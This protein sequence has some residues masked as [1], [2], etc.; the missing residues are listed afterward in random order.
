MQSEM[1]S[2]D[3]LRVNRIKSNQSSEKGT[4]QNTDSDCSLP[5]DRDLRT[6]RASTWGVGVLVLYLLYHR[7]HETTPCHNKSTRLPFICK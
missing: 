4:E 3:R 1:M 5:F 2:V 6:P 7:S